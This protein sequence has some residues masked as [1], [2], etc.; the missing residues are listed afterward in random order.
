MFYGELFGVSAGE[1]VRERDRKKGD[2]V[3]ILDK[4]TLARVGAR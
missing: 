1:R 3:E 2:K 4:G